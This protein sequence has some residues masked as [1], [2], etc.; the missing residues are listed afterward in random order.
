[1][2]VHRALVFHVEWRDARLD[3]LLKEFR[4]VVNKSIRFALNGDIRSRYR[5]VQAS[6]ANLS[7]E[8]AVYKQYIPS[9]FEVALGCLKAR[10]RRVCKG[11]AAS[12][13]YMKRLMLKAENQSYRLD[14]EMGR[15]RIPIRAKEYVTLD[16]PMSE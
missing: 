6:Y 12:K 8:H 3:W 2:R 5:L 7:R 4:L 11:K 1:M 13:P 9:A 16:L 10:R 15:L 14:R